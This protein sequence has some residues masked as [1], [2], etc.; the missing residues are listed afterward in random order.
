M[1]TCTRESGRTRNSCGYTHMK[2]MCCLSGNLGTSCMPYLLWVSNEVTE[3][4]LR[5]TCTQQV[6]GTCVSI[7]E[8]NLCAVS[9]VIEDILFPAMVRNGRKMTRR[10]TEA[11]KEEKAVFLQST[12]F[13]SLA[14]TLAL[15][16]ARK[17]VCGQDQSLGRIGFLSEKA[18]FMPTTHKDREIG[19][20]GR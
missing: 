20:N 9:Y 3:T 17:S 1:I 18:L 2:H 14:T 10:K 6:Y 7:H 5:Y 15:T 13:S 8:V 4:V 19:W 11:R 12:A 16:Q